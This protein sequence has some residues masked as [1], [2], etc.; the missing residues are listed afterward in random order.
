MYVTHVQC[1]NRPRQKLQRGGGRGLCPYIVSEII[2]SDLDESQEQARSPGGGGGAGW[3]E[4]PP[5]AK[6]SIGYSTKV[7]I[8]PK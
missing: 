4:D 3:S 2:S 6:G 7:H 1:L 5:W 8:F